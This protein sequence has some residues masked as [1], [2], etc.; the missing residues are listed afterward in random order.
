M[1]EKIHQI[2]FTEDEVTWQSMIYDL[3][4]TE[5]MNPWD[6]DVSLLTQ[7]Y[8]GMIQQFKELDFRVSGKVLLAAA[9]LLKIK[10]NRL[11]GE[12]LI[13]F[14]RLIAGNEE[15]LLGDFEEAV[16]YPGIEEEKPTLIPRTPQPRKRK[17]SIY[18][19]VGALEKA[20]EVKHRRVRNSI[21]PMG[22]RIPEK[23]RDI[24]QVIREVYGKIKTFFFKTQENK[25]MFSQLV[26][27]DNK[28]DKIY[29]LIPLLHLDHQRKI[30][31]HQEVPFADIEIMI[32][33]KKELDKEL[34]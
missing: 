23:T 11:V 16:E 34:S 25:L 19:L 6:I 33:T 24:T 21:P 15:E 22:V 10:S 29:T 5:Q 2:L 32:H 14:D 26:P 4:K 8:I 18:D 28:E 3:V 13:E 27:S 17:V 9:I 20:L 7:K 12:D 30:N 31:I 1:Q